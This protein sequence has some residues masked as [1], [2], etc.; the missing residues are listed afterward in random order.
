M[1]TETA[2]SRPSPAM[3]IGT[4]MTTPVLTVAAS[5]SAHEAF[6][7]MRKKGV[8]HLVVVDE[9]GRVKGVLSDGDLRSAQPSTLLVPDPAMRA[10]ALSMLKVRDVMTSDP[11]TARAGWSA[12]RLLQLMRD[13]KA[14]SVPVVDDTGHPVGVVTGMDVVRLSLRLL[15]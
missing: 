5:A 15:A 14:G 12:V 1:M 9:D 8:A 11:T 4:F 13:T 2:A 10:K 3:E 7:L 6:Q